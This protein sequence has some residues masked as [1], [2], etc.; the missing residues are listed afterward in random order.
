MLASHLA[1]GVRLSICTAL[2]FALS[3]VTSSVPRTRDRESLR[4]YVEQAAQR[5]LVRGA[6]VCPELT[7][8]QWRNGD[9]YVF[10]TNADTHV[11]VC[12]PANP[13]LVG[14]N[15]Y[16]LQD[17][18]GK[19]FVREMLDVAPLPASGGWVEYMWPRP[20]QTT[21]ARKTT[22]VIRVKSWDGATYLVGSGAYD[23]KP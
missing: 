14:R 5:V 10:V 21:P 12:H 11:T 18:N 13:E 17:V 20:G 8:Q 19:Y 1:T 16:D 4:K 15:E 2:L 7:N 6:E 23:L 22:Y 9:Y 3:C